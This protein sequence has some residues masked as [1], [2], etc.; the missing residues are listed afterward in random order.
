MPGDKRP[1]LAEGQIHEYRKRV[2]THDELLVWFEDTENN[3]GIITGESHGPVVVDIDSKEG[4]QAFN[5]VTQNTK[6][7]TPLVKTGRGYHLY[8]SMHNSGAKT[9]PGFIT[10]CDLKASG[11]YVVAPPSINGTGGAY[12][13]LRR[14]D[15]YDL[16]PLPS[17]ITSKIETFTSKMQARDSPWSLDKGLRDESLYSVAVS[18]YKG[19]LP[20][21]HADSVIT[22]LANSCNPPFS[23]EEALA[24]VR[25]AYENLPSERNIAEGVREWVSDSHGVFQIRELFQALCADKRAQRNIRS[26][27]ARL[28]NEKVLERVTGKNGF[29]RR[30]ID[31]LVPIDYINSTPSAH[32]P[33]SWPSHLPFGSMLVLYPGNIVVVAGSPNA[34]KTALMLNLMVLNQHKYPVNYFSNEI[35]GPELRARLSEF[36]HLD[37]NNMTFNAYELSRNFHD[38][39]EQNALNI[40]DYWQPGEEG[41]FYQIAEDLDKVHKKLAGTGLAVVCIQKKKGQ[42]LG[43][44]AEFSSERP[45]LYLSMDFQKIKLVKVKSPVPGKNPHNREYK[46]K[47]VRGCEFVDVFEITEPIL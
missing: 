19:G 27:I 43:R 40:I 47:L 22:L 6:Y 9:R 29:Y 23:S 16:Q 21:N 26:Y 46:F 38:Q 14:P 11:G 8:F 17:Q 35:Y 2:P 42:E 18:L 10:D 34:G 4:I 31:E 36:E 3:I 32:F 45:R 39:V 24:K 5:S 25:S 20:R 33:L 1:A 13:W 44:G 15:E 7:E 30:I 28:V 37:I 41:A 12:T